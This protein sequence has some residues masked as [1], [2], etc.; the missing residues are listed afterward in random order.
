MQ[1]LIALDMSDFVALAAQ[2]PELDKM[3]EDLREEWRAVTPAIS[4][5]LAARFKSEGPGWAPLAE[6]TQRDRLRRG[7]GAAHPILERKGDLR[8]SFLDGSE[9]IYEPDWMYYVSPSEIAPYHQ[10]GTRRMPAR[11]I[12]VRDELAGPVAE[13][14]ADAF[15]ARANREWHRV[16][17]RGAGARRSAGLEARGMMQHL[18]GITR[19]AA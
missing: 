6:S 2:I 19:S 9:Q 3:A 4:R 18:S 1:P 14:F 5:R 8:E 16:T 15:V 17:G 12:I 10:H 11:P 7:Y 13:A